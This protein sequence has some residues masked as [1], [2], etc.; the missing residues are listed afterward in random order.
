MTIVSV[1]VGTPKPVRVGDQTVLT[2]IWKSPVT[3]RVAVRPHNL[4]G[5][6]Q[7]DL[8]VHG[9]PYKAVYCY[10][11]EH[12]A[13][14]SEQL[15]D[16]ELVPGNFGENL[17]TR[18]V[19]ENEVCIGDRLRFGTAVL[20]V[21]QPRMPCF[22]LG[23]RFGRPDILKRFWNAG[24]SGIYF[25]IVEEGNLAAGDAI[26]PL[27]RAPGGITVADVVAL[28]KREKNSPELIERALGAPLYGGWKQGIR[29]RL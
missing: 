25:S 19:L 26:E 7:A 12:Y 15:P 24:R 29:E 13:Y 16:T 9:G 6:T 18:G 3:G 8:T 4:A 11:E 1:N 20:Q 14:W 17:T 28:Y 2:S 5:D 22:K 23:I 21:T 10:P 27:E